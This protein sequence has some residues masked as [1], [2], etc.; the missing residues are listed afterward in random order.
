MYMLLQLLCTFIWIQ[1]RKNNFQLSSNKMVMKS[2]AFKSRK[3][4]I[5]KECKRPL[6][7]HKNFYA[8]MIGQWMRL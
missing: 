4:F 2:V 3:V 8:I 1:I 5:D 7:I 6:L